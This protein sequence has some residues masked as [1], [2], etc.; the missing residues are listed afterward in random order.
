MER[1][2]RLNN[3]RLVSI[4]YVILAIVI[5]ILNFWLLNKGLI[6]SDEGWYL[7]LLRDL[8]VDCSTQFF[9]LFN[10]VFHN[11]IYA[12]RVT[13]YALRILSSMV[14]ALGLYKYAKY[15][16]E[17]INNNICYIVMLA[18]VIFG[19]MKII[20]TPSLNYITLNVI[21]SELSIGC[22]LIAISISNSVKFILGGI[23]GFFISMLFPIM[24]TNLICVPL[25]IIMLYVLSSKN[26]KLIISY[27]IGGVCFLLIYFCFIEDFHTYISV[28]LNNAQ[29]TINRG[30]SGHG[31]TFLY[32]WL[33]RTFAHYYMPMILVAMSL[34][35]MFM[36]TKGCSI[37][38]KV[39]IY[40]LVFIILLLYIRAIAWYKIV[41]L[42][43]I[44][45][46]TLILM[47]KNS[48]AKWIFIIS[49]L[50]M[51][52]CLSFGT[53]V[54][55]ESRCSYYLSFV[56]PLMYMYSGDN[57][58]KRIVD[59]MIILSF[60]VYLYTF[61]QP[62]WHGEKYYEQK[63][64]V[65]NLG[66]SQNIKL[67]KTNYDRLSYVQQIIP[68]G[69]QVLIDNEYWGMASLLEWKPITHNI[70]ITQDALQHISKT[71]KVDY[72]IITCDSNN[73]M[74]LDTNIQFEKYQY[75]NIRIYLIK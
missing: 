7:C 69:S 18:F 26:W 11:N 35:F 13:C 16:N 10:N 38:S 44:T 9:F 5:L 25:L 61:T 63:Y 12:I 43:F 31:L 47:D 53:D 23:S 72:V 2:D 40:I 45:T 30:N 55:C 33:Y 20:A 71:D 21:V 4:L 42:V 59:I 36:K 22:L 28:F 48:V 6:M 49:L 46:Y 14:F 3:I 50:L 37:R 58:S 56:F 32:K 73:M 8:P 75:Q 1:I 34:C 74:I 52:L 66:I 51:P 68:N 57:I 41:W 39:A 27:I 70:K 15:N 67:D 60:V 29:D 17:F 19:Q 24:I 54:S 64:S 62:N 65:E